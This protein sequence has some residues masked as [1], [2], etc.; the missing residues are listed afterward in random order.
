MIIVD[1]HMRCRTQLVRQRQHRN[2]WLSS[3]T[4]SGNPNTLATA[5]RMPREWKT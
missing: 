5:D 1:D 4:K 3:T 2:F